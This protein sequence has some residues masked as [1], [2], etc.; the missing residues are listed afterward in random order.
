VASIKVSNTHTHTH[1]THKYIVPK[2]IGRY[3]DGKIVSRFKLKMIVNNYA[4][5]QYDFQNN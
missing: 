1:P 2:K 5:L 4:F 3:G